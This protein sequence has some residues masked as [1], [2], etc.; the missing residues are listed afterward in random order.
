MHL[1]E[2]C[3]VDAPHL[4]TQVHTTI[5]PAHDV[6]HLLAIQQSLAERHLLPAQQLVDTGYTSVR[7]LARKPDALPD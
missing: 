1:T 5:A 2:T 7:N 4:I 6:E 3:D